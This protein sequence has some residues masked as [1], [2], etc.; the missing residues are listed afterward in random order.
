MTLWAVDSSSVVICPYF[1]EDSDAGVQTV[2]S[3]RYM[4]LL[5]RIFVPTTGKNTLIS[6]MSAGIR[7]MVK[8]LTSLY[9]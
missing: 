5:G 4:H 8:H 7:K 1:F 3:G 9:K 6:I 2:N